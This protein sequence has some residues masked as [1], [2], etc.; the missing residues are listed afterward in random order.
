MNLVKRFA[1]PAEK[2]M[3]CDGITISAPNTINYLIMSTTTA[4]P[5]K[6]SRTKP[7]GKKDISPLDL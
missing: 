2:T 5:K 4:A 7:T 6:K 1:E 3:P